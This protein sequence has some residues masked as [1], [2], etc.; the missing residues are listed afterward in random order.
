MA[1]TRAGA[2]NALGAR[3]KEEERSAAELRAHLIAAEE[4]AAALAMRVDF[5]QRVVTA[6]GVSLHLARGRETAL[7]STVSMLQAQV[8]AYAE[9]LQN[10]A[11]QKSATTSASAL[12]Y[13]LRAPSPLRSPRAASPLRSASH[14]Q[15]SSPTADAQT[16]AAGSNGDAALPSQALLELPPMSSLS[17]RQCLLVWSQCN[18][19]A[20]GY[21]AYSKRAR[22]TFYRVQRVAQIVEALGVEHGAQEAVALVEAYV[23]SRTVGE[24]LWRGGKAAHFVAMIRK[25]GD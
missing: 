14:V 8:A 22:E 13:S 2:F 1:T 18:D 21:A 11:Q 15:L 4:R 6:T 16:I 24:S 7:V 23:G 3:L 5:L 19:S 9:D 12:R 20:G 10:A 17:V 25:M